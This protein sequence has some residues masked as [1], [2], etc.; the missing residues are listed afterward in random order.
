[1]GWERCS[2]LFVMG[3]F[4]ER[5]AVLRLCLEKVEK[6]ILC[7]VCAGNVLRKINLALFVLGM[8][9]CALFELEKHWEK[10]SVLC[11]LEMRWEKCLS[12]FVLGMHWKRYLVLCLFIYIFSKYS[13]VSFELGM[14]WKRN[15][16]CRLSWE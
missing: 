8:R 11:L 13:Y 2:T 7:F 1:M 6:E 14:C 12:L 5:D 9:F 10:D 15:A 3:M 4:W 16:W